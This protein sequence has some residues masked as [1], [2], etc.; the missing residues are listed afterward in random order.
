MLIDTHAH[1]NFLEYSQPGDET[2]ARCLSYPAQVVN[3]GVDYDSSEQ[4]IALAEKYPGS[5]FASVGLHPDDGFDKDFNIDQFRQLISDHRSAV[6]AIG[7]CGLDFYRWTE[8]GSNFEEVYQK[9]VDIFRQQI[10]LAREFNLPLVIH[11][12]AS[13]DS[14]KP[15]AY[16]EIIK[17]LQAEDYHLGTAHCFSGTVAEAEQFLDLGFYL[18]FTGIITFPKGDNVREIAQ[19]CP[20]DRM[21]IETD[22]P[23]LAPQAYRGK[24]NEP[25]YVEEVAKKIAEIRGWSLAETIELNAQNANKLF[26]LS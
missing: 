2:I 4:V 18:G 12:R 6:V 7:E 15:Q 25:I 14:D 23:F 9:Q 11:A 13:K 20:R 1:L 3:I 19:I 8:L 16:T 24:R 22:A 17:I 26:N 21:L 5:F 10:A